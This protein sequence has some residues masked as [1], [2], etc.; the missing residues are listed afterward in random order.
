[1]NENNRLSK[2]QRE[3]IRLMPDCPSVERAIAGIITA[4]D[5]SRL[6]GKVRLKDYE[7]SMKGN[8]DREEKVCP[9]N[10]N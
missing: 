4:C 8:G 3:G 6:T 9:I 5:I 10:S 7:E 1:M 2:A